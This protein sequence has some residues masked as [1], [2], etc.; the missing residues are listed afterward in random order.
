MSCAPAPQPPCLLLQAKAIA[1][2]ALPLI[3]LL[4]VLS[5]I[6]ILSAHVVAREHHRQVGHEDG[7]DGGADAQDKWRRHGA[8]PTILEFFVYN[9]FLLI[10]IIRNEIIVFREQHVPPCLR[11]SAWQIA[12]GRC[13][14]APG[15]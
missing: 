15:T 11:L 8:P 3:E 1:R 12:D 9:L 13:R 6:I 7:D 5:T 14:R 2:R 10:I 4:F